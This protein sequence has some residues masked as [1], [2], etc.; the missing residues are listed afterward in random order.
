MSIGFI[1][2]VMNTDNMTISGE[3]IDYGPCA[4]MDRYDP[5]TFFSSIDTQGRY[6]YSNQPLILSWN[7]ARFAETLIPL[8]DKD[9]DKAI[10]LLSEKIISIKSE[11][12]EEW[13]KVMAKKIGITDIKND[14]LILLNNLLDIMNE[15]NA[16]F[17]LTF[18][19]LSE[20]IIGD[21]NLFYNLF[22]SKE[23]IN[24]WVITWK[25][26]IKEDSKL[27]ESFSLKLNKNNP[28]YI[29]RNHIVEDVLSKALF[30]KNFK[31]FHE[32]YEILINP[33]N[34]VP[35]SE[36]YTLPAPI[37]DKPYKTFCGT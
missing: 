13:F 33:Y 3:T 7:L 14:D 12:E 9:Q 15:N 35:N 19:Y 26:R 11:Y 37:T 18:R 22:R 27:D 20:L 36:Q 23:K 8:I 10:Q 16:D 32:F 34:E 21:E 1:H 25:G 30:E 17:T 4:F 29:P 5:N 2:G 24:K 31:P 6:A 28:L